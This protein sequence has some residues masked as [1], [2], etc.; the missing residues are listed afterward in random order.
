MATKINGGLDAQCASF[1][2]DNSSFLFVVIFKFSSYH[3]TKPKS[4]SWFSST[5]TFFGFRFLFC[6][7]K[8]AA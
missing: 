6:S 3:A 7:S 8:S 1:A 4:D 5:A 2:A